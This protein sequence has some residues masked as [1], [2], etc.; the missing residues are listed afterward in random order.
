[1]AGAGFQVAFKG[2]GDLSIL[3]GHVRF[4]LPGSVCFAVS[5]VASIVFNQSLLDVLSTSNVEAFGIVETSQNID[6][7]HQHLQALCYAPPSAELRSSVF[8]ARPRRSHGEGELGASKL[9]HESGRAKK[10][11][12]PVDAVRTL[13]D[14]GWNV[15]LRDF[16]R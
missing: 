15:F 11:G 9:D 2:F 4:Q 5:A 7:M 8:F 16:K 1:M 10:T 14:E 6:E 12:E 13:S 3:E